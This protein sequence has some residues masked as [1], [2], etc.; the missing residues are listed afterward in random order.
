[1]DGSIQENRHWVEMVK[2]LARGG[3]LP[4]NLSAL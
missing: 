4:T 2:N 1:V 3:T